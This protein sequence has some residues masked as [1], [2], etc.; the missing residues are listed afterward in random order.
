MPR[1]EEGY[2][3]RRQQIIDGALRVF[4][5]K[6]FAQAT[7]KEIAQAAG[8]GSP[9][10]IYHYFA[11]KNDLL[12]QIFAAQVPIASLLDKP[13]ALFDLPVRE[14]LTLLAHS[15]LQILQKRA[16]IDRLKLLLGEVTRQPDLLAVV[17]ELGP[18]RVFALLG[19][20]LE[21]QMAAGVLRQ[22]EPAIAVRCFM[23]PLVLYILT[24]A[25][26]HMP[27]AQS[28]PPEQMATEAVELFLTG[29]LI[30][31]P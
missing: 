14:G 16:F 13:E 5:Q 12:G 9:G 8:I 2:N 1:N 30:N 27:D 31:R 4:A 18:T 22:M 11:D 3:E 29:M 26:L 10:L 24:R 28:I 15:F 25:V 21:R 20:Y 23:G 19:A 7:I 6:G 17:T